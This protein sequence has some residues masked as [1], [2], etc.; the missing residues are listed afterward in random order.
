MDEVEV[1]VSGSALSFNNVGATTIIINNNNK[2]RART[3]K[4]LARSGLLGLSLSLSFLLTAC[5]YDTAGN[6]SGNPTPV[7]APSFTGGKPQPTNLGAASFLVDGIA[8][9]LNDLAKFIGQVGIGIFK[10]FIT[11]AE[12]FDLTRSGNFRQCSI[13]N[14]NL[15]NAADPLVGC[16][17][18]LFDQIKYLPAA[19]LSFAFLYFALKYLF[20]GLVGGAVPSFWDFVI[21][22]F[23]TTLFAFNL[24]FVITAIVD[25]FSK[26]FFFI[27]SYS[28]SPTSVSSGTAGGTATGTGE[29]AD[30]LDALA[31]LFDISKIHNNNLAV[32]AVLVLVCLPAM[33]SLIIMAVFFFTRFILFLIYFIL[34]VPAITARLFDETAFFFGS[35]WKGLLKLAASSLPLAFVIKLGIAVSTALASSSSGGGGGGSSSTAPDPIFYI[36]SMLIITLIFLL[37]AAYAFWMLTSDLREAAQVATQVRERASGIVERFSG[38][39]AG[40]STTTTSTSRTA[41]N[42]AASAG[43]KGGT[44]QP[45]TQKTANNKQ[46]SSSLPLALPAAAASTSSSGA[47]SGGSAPV[48]ASPPLTS[49]MLSTAISTGLTQA[50]TAQN[51]QNERV[52]GALL[53]QLTGLRI[54]LEEIRAGM[55]NISQQS[56]NSLG[57]TSRMSEQV[58]QELR[59]LRSDLIATQT[60]ARNDY[61]GNGNGNGNNSL[62][63]GGTQNARASSATGGS[64]ST[65]GLD[66]ARA[67][68]AAGAGPLTAM[69]K[70]LDGETARLARLSASLAP[71]QGSFSSASTST[72]AAAN[73]YRPGGVPVPLEAS[74]SATRLPLPP[75]AQPQVTSASYPPQAGGAG[76]GRGGGGYAN[77]YARPGSS[78]SSNSGNYYYPP[79][80][81]Q[82]QDG[83]EAAFR[84]GREEVGW[85]VGAAS[86]YA[87]HPTPT[88]GG[89]SYYYDPSATR[90]S[91]GDVRRFSRPIQYRRLNPTNTGFS[92]SSSP[93]P[94]RGL[95]QTDTT[96]QP[97]AGA[98]VNSVNGGS[99]GGNDIE[100]GG[101]NLTPTPPPTTSFRIRSVNYRPSAGLGQGLVASQS[102]SP[103]P[104]MAVVQRRT[105]QPQTRQWGYPATTNTSAPGYYNPSAPNAL[106]AGVSQSQQVRGGGGGYSFTSSATPP[107]NY[108]QQMPSAPA[109]AGGGNRVVPVSVSG[110]GTGTGAGGGA[111]APGRVSAPAPDD[112]NGNGFNATMIINPNTGLP[113][114]ARRLKPGRVV[115]SR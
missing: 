17:V 87:I 18:S 54:V 111:I 80:L 79:L 41:T 36:V 107:P 100:G 35:W 1:S 52:S 95:A 98:R 21:N 85:G 13:S 86:N 101:A 57:Q 10:W 28:P 92:P 105:W 66:S 19:L 77:P 113:F 26:L 93:S 15:T 6:S 64:A 72:A 53:N 24:D 3:S 61:G 49:Q 76:R 34:G 7:T 58:I 38:N 67:A 74:A 51:V 59:H 16:A 48:V 45:Q 50:F 32:A 94:S 8:G 20:R 99:G 63:R 47:G 30:G 46:P 82:G 25:I 40:S 114:Q 97:G 43:G 112:D 70:M 104:S 115:V 103:S 9:F 55:R 2:K 88:T 110:A 4:F 37:G 78:S 23:V 33:L 5:S 81:G 44:N 11:T 60:Q 65:S 73:S 108:A 84:T 96:S 69:M 91:G 39:G 42:T 56:V 29:L 102:S 71:A 83:N 31:A 89:G 109:P 22:V 27:V 106:L 90:N 68:A 62:Y 12:G 14:L 75:P